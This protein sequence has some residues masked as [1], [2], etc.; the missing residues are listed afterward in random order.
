MDAWTD[1]WMEGYMDGWMNGCMEVYIDRCL[2]GW[3]DGYI[4]G[5][6][7]YISIQYPIN[8]H[9]HHGFYMVFMP[10]YVGRYGTFCYY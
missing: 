2:D 3:M 1:G 5:I 4:D 7:Y 8:I 6:Q 9:V 10:W